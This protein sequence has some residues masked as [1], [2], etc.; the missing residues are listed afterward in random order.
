MRHLT[1]AEADRSLHLVASSQELGSLVQL[2]VEV[3]GVNIER[4]AGLLDLDHFLVLLGFLLLLLLFKTVFAV[5]QH[6]AHRRG[7]LRC[8]LDQIEP[9]FFCSAHGHLNG[10]NAL[11]LAIGTD[12]AN[13]T[14]TDLTVDLQFLRLSSGSDNECTSKQNP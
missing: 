11:L 14:I 2:G 10:H 7:S 4:K 1:A 5:I 12:Q 13:F 8:D 6:L 3:V 9:G